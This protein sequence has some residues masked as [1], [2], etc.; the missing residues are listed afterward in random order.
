M[1]SASAGG[2]V[3][4]RAWATRWA[5]LAPPDAPVYCAEYRFHPTRKWRFDCAF[6]DRKVAVEL[7][8]G[9]YTGGRHTRGKGY[10]QDI[11][12]YNAAVVLG[13][14][15]L[16]FTAG[17]LERDPLGCVALVVTVLAQSPAVAI[18]T[19]T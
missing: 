18:L 5:Q 15:L 19:I 1:T 6:P 12:K 14:R 3:L 13:W 11:E 9:T 8:G 17:Q 4:E 16:R 2:S 7:E 10:E